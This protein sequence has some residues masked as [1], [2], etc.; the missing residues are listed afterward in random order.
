MSFS[1]SLSYKELEALSLCICVSSEWR[2]S[3]INPELGHV[4][5][6]CLCIILSNLLQILLEVTPLQIHFAVYFQV[7]LASW[8]KNDSF[9]MICSFLAVVQGKL[10]LPCMWVSRCYKAAVA[11]GGTQS[12]GGPGLMSQGSLPGHKVPVTH[13][14]HITPTRRKPTAPEPQ[15]WLCGLP[16]PTYHVRKT[17]G[18]KTVV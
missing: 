11:S 15:S 8:L 14:K 3:E 10:L 6:R 9:Y 17:Q 7:W 13:L 2:C 4:Y 18:L 5:G 16:M 12:R 1:K